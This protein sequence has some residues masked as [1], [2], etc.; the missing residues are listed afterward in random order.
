M[1]R[2]ELGKVAS[3]RDVVFWIENMQL[4]ACKGTKK[5]QKQPR[6]KENVCKNKT[7]CKLC[8]AFWKNLLTFA[9]I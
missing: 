3:Q 4:H 7:F 8:F 1:W 5:T 2:G 9:K 6:I